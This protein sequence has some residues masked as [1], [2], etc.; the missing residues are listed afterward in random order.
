M[1]FFRFESGLIL[2]L[3]VVAGCEKSGPALL[4][5]EP[6]TKKQA[7]VGGEDGGHPS[8]GLVVMEGAG[9][10]GTVISARMV[11]TAA[12]CATEEHPPQFFLLGNSGEEAEAVIEVVEVFQHWGYDGDRTS[13]PELGMANDI[14]LLLLAEPAPVEP[15]RFR[16]D[17]LDCME[18]TPVQF[19]G[20]GLTDG[21]DP[22]SSGSKHNVWVNIKQMVDTGFWTGTIPGDPKNACP[23]DSGGPVLI[24]EGD[25]T[26]V[27]GVLS[28][29]DKWC[30]W[31][32][33]AVRTDVQTAWIMGLVQAHDPDG[34]PPDCEG[35]DCV[36]CASPETGT[37]CGCGQVCLVKD[38]G[39]ECAVHD[40]PESNCGN[41]KCEA[42]EDWGNCAFDCLKPS[43]DVVEEVGCCVGDVA[44]WCNEGQM[45]MQNC[46]AAPSCGWDG[47]SAR[48]SCGTDGKP[49]P[50]G[51]A[52]KACQP[53][54]PDCGN[55]LCEIGENDTV[56]PVD[57]LYPGFCG[58]GV[59]DG[60]EHF[61][62]CPEDCKENICDIDPPW[63]CCDGDVAVYCWGGDLVKM[64]CQHHPACGWDG[65][66]SAY[67]CD[68][69]GQ[70]EPTGDVPMDCMAY[71]PD[72]CG[73]GKCGW[74]ETWETCPQDCDPLPEGCG[75]GACGPG[76]DYT[77]CPQDCYKAGC[78]KIGEQG[79]CDAGLVKWCIGD[80]LFMVNCENEPVCGW[81][82][83]DGYYW[84]ATA[85]EDEPTGMY[86]LSCEE[87]ENAFCGDAKCQMGENKYTCPEDCTPPDQCGN[88]LCE[89][90]EDAAACPEDCA[91]DFAPEAEPDVTA[92]P[93]LAPAEIAADTAAPDAAPGSSAS[94]GGCGH[95]PAG[96]GSCPWP[97]GLLVCLLLVWRLAP[98]IRRRS[99]L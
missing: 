92:T 1:K 70:P 50:S 5:G 8:V 9:C 64:S 28:L 94:S 26:T 75:D 78:G 33:F 61:A 16:K 45:Y 98:S 86:P 74:D 58:D 12:H 6:A 2:V 23:G 60:L 76:E 15:L 18:G 77:S 72:P 88:G 47:E 85:G 54:G 66:L 46:T 82:Q 63:G 30:E 53:F 59:C 71:E 48:Y 10:S 43:C 19:V 13:D 90:S 14:A 11:L 57:C 81:S 32:T 35:E 56:C 29:A 31:D 73:D 25:R 36:G 44:Y 40:F 17:S 96:S 24:V 39:T 41:G 52:P 37:G 4:K 55:G 22:A 42:G 99:G 89:E 21:S 3:L 79:C 49:D 84:C 62:L 68:T 80:S 7:I 51:V 91:A 34:L 38:E 97:M 95:L 65:E 69:D 93:D 83:D 20:Y 87:V 27:V 67:T